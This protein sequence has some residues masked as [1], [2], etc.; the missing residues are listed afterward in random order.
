MTGGHQGCQQACSVSAYVQARTEAAEKD[1]ATVKERAWALMEEKDAQLQAAK[2]RVVTQIMISK[3]GLV[4]DRE[5]FK[6]LSFFFVPASWSVLSRTFPKHC[7]GKPLPTQRSCCCTGAAAAPDRI[8]RVAA[9][10]VALRAA[11]CAGH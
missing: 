5:G 3:Q 2:V 9:A 10:T 1:L 7:S 8:Y 6:K 4:W 11:I